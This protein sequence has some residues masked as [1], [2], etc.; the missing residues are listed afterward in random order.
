[1]NK[2]PTLGQE[3]VRHALLIVASIV[4]LYPL[5]WMIASSFK[6]DELIFSNPTALPRSLDLSNYIEGWN[7]LRVSFTTFYWNSFLI[8]GLAVVALTATTGS[9]RQ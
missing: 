7:A 4:M 8:A 6:P 1:M 9:R 2:K 3:I 5:L